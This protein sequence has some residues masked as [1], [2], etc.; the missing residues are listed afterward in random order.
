MTGRIRTAVR[1]AGI[2]QGVGFRPFVYSLAT[3]LGLGGSSATT[4][5]ACSPRSRATRPAVAEFLARAGAQ[6]AAAGRDRRGRRRRGPARRPGR[7]AFTIAPSRDRR[8]ARRGAGLGRTPR[9]CDDCLAELA[10]PADRRYRYPFINC[11]NC[12]P[13]FTIVTDVPYDRPLTT[14]A[15]FADVRALRGRVPR[16][17]RPPVP[18][19]AGRAARPAARG[20]ASVHRPPGGRSMPGRPRARSPPPRRCCGPARSSRSRASAATTWPPTRPARRRSRALR[21]RKHREDKPFAVMVADLAA[22]RRLC[23]VDEAAARPAGQ[24]AGGRSC[25]CRRRTG[26]AAGR[27]RRSRRATGTSA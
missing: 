15:G 5:T 13:R 17:G 26:G 21:A 23:E 3:G 14:M 20:C 7:R 18:R 24:R 8:G 25:C 6:R 10:D 11:T 4:P 12:G 9:P 19:P 1:V 22:A 16:P 2:V 27:R